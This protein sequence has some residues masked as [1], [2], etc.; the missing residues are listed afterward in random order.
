MIVINVYEDYDKEYALLVTYTIEGF[1]HT[2]GKRL[3]VTSNKNGA[4][5]ILSSSFVI[6]DVK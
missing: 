2:T 5:S 1:I 6:G 4:P 3:V